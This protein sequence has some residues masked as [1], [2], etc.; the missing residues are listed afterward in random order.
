MS[1]VASLFILFMLMELGLCLVRKEIFEIIHYHNIVIREDIFYCHSV[2]LECMVSL[3]L[4][5]APWVL[6]KMGRKFVKQCLSILR[7]WSH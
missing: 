6:E 7:C 4:L 5:S 1:L 2:D 3:M